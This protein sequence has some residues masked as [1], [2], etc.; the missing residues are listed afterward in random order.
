MAIEVLWLSI[1]L[2]G[3]I[4]LCRVLKQDETHW[5]LMPP[6][7][8]YGYGRE[9]RGPRYGSLIHGQNLKNVIITGGFVMFVR[10]NL[11]AR[12]SLDH[13]FKVL[14]SLHRTAIKAARLY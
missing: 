1:C 6:L 4:F 7:P 3:G 14:Y 11:S 10:Y 13:L 12:T 5:P 2:S 9:H 8:S